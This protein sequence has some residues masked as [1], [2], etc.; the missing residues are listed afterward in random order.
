M[1]GVIGASSR[2][3]QRLLSEW[4]HAARAQWPLIVSMHKADRL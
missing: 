2:T 4:P 1:D 3:A